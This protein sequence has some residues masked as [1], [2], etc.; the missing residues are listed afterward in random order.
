MMPNP[1]PARLPASQMLAPSSLP[2]RQV[3]VNLL[4]FQVSWFAA[5]LGAANGMAWL[6]SLVVALN[7]ARHLRGA[8]NPKFEALLITA[9][10]LAGGL[11][12]LFPFALGWIG[13]P[14]HATAFVPLW[15]IALWMNFASVL[16][17]SLRSLRYRPWLLA[18]LG[19]VGGPAA[20][21]GGASLGAMEWLKPLPALLYLAIGWALLTPLL[22]RLALRLD[23]FAH[24][25]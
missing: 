11:F 10:A 13:Y 20:Y 5:V 8:V 19:A 14:G 1:A 4:W 6:G 3:V 16:N 24:G 9:A 15:M 7:L 17:V 25:H 2:P 18:L 21:W 23:G 22:A 12:E